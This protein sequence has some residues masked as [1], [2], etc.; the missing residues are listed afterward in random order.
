[1]ASP[2]ERSIGGLG[3]CWMVFDRRRGRNPAFVWHSHQIVVHAGA[4]SSTIAT[5]SQVR[6]TRV[7]L[8]N[9]PDAI[10]DDSG[11]A[12]TTSARRIAPMLCGA[13]PSRVEL[14]HRRKKRERAPAAVHTRHATNHTITHATALSPIYSGSFDF[15][16]RRPVPLPADNCCITISA[17][18]STE[19]RL[20]G[21]ALINFLNSPFKS[22][23]LILRRRRH[24]VRCPWYVVVARV[25][26][27]GL[28]LA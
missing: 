19:F 10:A 27:P 14:E 6:R 24:Y 20:L 13:P 5:I 18:A 17:Q 26:V 12:V 16:P 1:M 7:A 2:R 21:L 28:L 22:S 11:E 8:D 9:D 4:R 23:V 25:V 15:L 3:A